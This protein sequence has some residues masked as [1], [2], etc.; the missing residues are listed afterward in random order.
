[1]PR[2]GLILLCSLVAC[3]GR[4]VPDYGDG[5][6]TDVG[7]VADA[8]QPLDAGACV[9]AENPCG[10][11]MI[12]SD[13]RPCLP[14]EDWCTH[15]H[16]CE[17]DSPYWCRPRASCDAMPFC[18]ENE[19][20]SDVP[21]GLAEEDC[22]TRTECDTALH[23]RNERTCI[24][25]GPVACPPNSAPSQS[26]CGLDEPDCTA[27]YGCNRATEPATLWC[28]AVASCST[29]PSCDRGQAT[30]YPCTLNEVHCER[31]TSCGQTLFCRY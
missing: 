26:P 27:H 2:V 14:W 5:G 11:R 13:T 25:G 9:A 10:D 29:P 24:S 17:D 12:A 15:V 18:L 21:C 4:H 20:A 3:S 30:D 1:M 8:A 28:R 19:T 23:C 31:V 7:A 22:T 16:T 6:V